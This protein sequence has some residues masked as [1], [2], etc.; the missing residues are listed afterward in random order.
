MDCIEFDRSDFACLFPAEKP[1]VKRK[2][3]EIA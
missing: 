2:N 3:A 1:P